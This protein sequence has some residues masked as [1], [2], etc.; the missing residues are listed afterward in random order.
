M[1]NILLILYFNGVLS[2]LFFNAFHL[3][4]M[5]DNFEIVNF[6]SKQDFFKDII[7]EKDM[8]V[9]FNLSFGSL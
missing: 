5:S 7:N 3:S 2:F 6:L 9:H 8:I 4:V 1:Q